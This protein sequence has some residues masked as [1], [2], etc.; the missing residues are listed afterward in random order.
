[1]SKRKGFRERR[2]HK[3][4]EMPTDSFVTLGPQGTII[5]KI[6]DMSA[7]GLSFGYIDGQES[8]KKLS[9]LDIFCMDNGFRLKE[10][11]FKTAWEFETPNELPA[12]S[13][14]MRRSGVRFKKLSRGQRSQLKDFL[15]NHPTGDL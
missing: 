15:E 4:F 11:R 8:V 9:E 3:R 1:M 2:K 6:V 5:G 14:T 10:V 12:S 13:Q 7:G